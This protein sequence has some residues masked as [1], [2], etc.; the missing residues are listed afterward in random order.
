MDTNTRVHTPVIKEPVDI[1]IF[2]GCQPVQ[3][4]QETRMAFT[5]SITFPFTVTKS[6]LRVTLPAKVTKQLSYSEIFQMHPNL[7]NRNTEN[8]GARFLTMNRIDSITSFQVISSNVLRG[9][10]I[11]I[12]TTNQSFPFCGY[13]PIS[14]LA[15]LYPPLQV[16]SV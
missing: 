10:T 13:F 14:H 8:N 6:T 2:Y 11:I 9:I 1:S 4:M 15:V 12:L 3:V 16:I 5:K 7:G